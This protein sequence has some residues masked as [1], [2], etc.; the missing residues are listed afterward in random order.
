MLDTS[1]TRRVHRDN[2]FMGINKED[3]LRKSWLED[4]LVRVGVSFTGS[5]MEGLTSLA[6]DGDVPC[7]EC[8]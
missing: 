7:I 6:Q 5:S 8:T 4:S 1:S 2:G 3:R